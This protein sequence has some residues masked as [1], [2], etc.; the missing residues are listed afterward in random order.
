MINDDSIFH[1]RRVVEK[2][3][4]LDKKIGLVDGLK[5]C[6]KIVSGHVIRSDLTEPRSLSEL[7][8][9]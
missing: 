7:H 1:D 8:D 3:E 6:V 9:I 4:K 5:D 2:R